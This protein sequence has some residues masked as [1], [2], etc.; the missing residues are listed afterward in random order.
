MDTTTTTTTTEKT[1]TIYDDLDTTKHDK[2]VTNTYTNDE[3]NIS[4]NQDKID[5]QIYETFTSNNNLL[6]ENLND[7]MQESVSIWHVL[8]LTENEYNEKY[9]KKI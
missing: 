1:T 6:P 9:N 2:N 8:G 4:K 3:S 5:K 7:F